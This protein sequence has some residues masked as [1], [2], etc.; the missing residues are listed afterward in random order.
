MDVQVRLLS[1][2]PFP[3]PLHPCSSS[4][5]LRRVGGSHVRTADAE[6]IVGRFPE[7]LEVPGVR[8]G[9]R[10]AGTGCRAAPGRRHRVAPRTRT[11]SAAG[12]RSAAH[13]MRGERASRREE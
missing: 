4:R 7:L 13:S 5:I 8:A 10:A 2:A 6:A 11:G 12:R 1:P 3:L 9:E